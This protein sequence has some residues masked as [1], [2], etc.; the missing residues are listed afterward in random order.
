MN[1]FFIIGFIL[2]LIGDV[3]QLYYTTNKLITIGITIISLCI[4]LILGVIY[5]DKKEKNG[6]HNSL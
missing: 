3:V 4:V 5:S 1:K 2:L 6:K